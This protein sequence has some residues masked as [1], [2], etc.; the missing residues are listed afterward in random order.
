MNAKYANWLIPLAALSAS[1]SAL[2]G[3]DFKG[4]ELSC[5]AKSG[6]SC[7]GG[8][9]GVSGALDMP[10]A[11]ASGSLAAATED[12]AGSAG[13]G[14][15]AGADDHGSA[16]TSSVAGTPSTGG[17]GGQDTAETAG[18]GAVGGTTDRSTGGS[19]GSTS[20]GGAG[21]AA[22]TAAGTGGIGVGSTGG[23]VIGTGGNSQPGGGNGNGGN[24]GSKTL[25]LDCQPD[26]TIVPECTMYG[27]PNGDYPPV[28]VNAVNGVAIWSTALYGGGFN[29]FG[30]KRGVSTIAQRYTRTAGPDPEWTGW[31]CFDALPKPARMAAGSLTNGMAEAFATSSC[32]TLY[33]RTQIPDGSWFAPWQPFTLPT[34]GA[35]VTDVAMSLDKDGVNLVYVADAGR[36]FMRHRASAEPYSAYTVWQEIPAG[37]A[38]ILLAAGLRSDHRQQVFVLDPQGALYTAVQDDPNLDSAFGPWQAF[39]MNE[40]SAPLVDVEVP[41]GT[42]LEVFATAG[43]G[44]LWQGNGSL[45]AGAWTAWDGPA[46]LTPLFT[47]AGSALLNATGAP[48]VLVGS[49]LSGGVYTIRRYQNAWRQWT[50]LY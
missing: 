44:T 22:D 6:V 21:G 27:G 11:G 36:V 39:D 30:T 40:F 5:L 8:N 14:G 12:L 13:Q 33:R 49:S 20:A 17:K 37:P 50:Q 19:A 48:L 26:A 23:G 34:P 25:P 16:G 3:D 31:Y 41:S 10:G 46:P 32:G 2:I 43:N 29:V 42:S 24:G 1:C 15:Q 47:L 18:N 9:A 38:A 4:Y 45:A 35:F 7:A 28:N